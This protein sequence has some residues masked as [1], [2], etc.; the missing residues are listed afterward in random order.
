MKD[1]DGIITSSPLP[2]PSELS[3]AWSAAVPLLKVTE[4]FVP[5]YFEYFFSKISTYLPLTNLPLKIIFLSDLYSFKPV[6]GIATLINLNY[7]FLMFYYFFF[8]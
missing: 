2:K 1:I 6:I 5:I 7:R 4:Y 8:I 3:A